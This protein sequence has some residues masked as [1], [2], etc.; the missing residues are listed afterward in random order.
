MAYISGWWPVEGINSHAE[1]TQSSPTRTSDEDVPTTHPW[2]FWISMKFHEHPWTSR[3][4]LHWKQQLHSEHSKHPFKPT[5]GSASP[6]SMVP[7]VKRRLDLD[8]W[9]TLQRGTEFC[10]FMAFQ[11]ATWSHVATPSL[12]SL[13]GGTSHL[14]TSEKALKQFDVETSPKKRALFSPRPISRSLHLCKKCCKKWL[15]G[16]IKIH[17]CC[18]PPPLHSTNLYKGHWVP[19]RH[20]Y[21][22]TFPEK[23]I[24]W[25][26]WPTN[27]HRVV[28][29]WA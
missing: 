7:T 11:D 10:C 2:I 5:T 13:G 20:R 12:L 29:P 6:E 15:K 9:Q 26:T 3:K 8:T 16:Q 18:H 21:Q 17:R 28:A 24:K 23:K 14:K 1:L 22:P 25:A 19:T 4:Q 27:P